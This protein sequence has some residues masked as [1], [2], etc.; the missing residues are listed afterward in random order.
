MSDVS[1][2]CPR[3]LR[4]VLRPCSTDEECLDCIQFLRRRSEHTGTLS[5][6]ACDGRC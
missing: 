6:R 3:C 2:T 5:T 1:T 4:V